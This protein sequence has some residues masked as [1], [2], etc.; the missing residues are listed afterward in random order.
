M[1]IG[2]ITTSYKPIWGG[3]EVYVHN[4]LNVFF[5]HGFEQRVYQ[6]DTGLKE[7][8]I[9]NLR[10]MKSLQK[11]IGFATTYNLSLLSKINMLKSEDV[12][13]IHYPIHFYPIW[14][15]P[16]TILLSHGVTWNCDPYFKKKIK[17]GLD[18]FAYSLCEK[19]VANESSYFREMGLAI[20]PNN[21]L[22]CEVAKNKWFIPN[23]VD[24]NKFQKVKPDNKLKK[25][26][27]I[28]VP[29]NIAYARGIHLAVLAFAKFVK[30]HSDTKLALV[31]ETIEAVRHSDRYKRYLINLISKLN[32]NDKVIF[33]GRIPWNE[34]NRIYS[35]SIMTLIPSLGVE[36]TSL[37][38]LESMACGTATLSTDRGGLADLPTVHCEA[39]EESLL[40][41]M[42]EVFEDHERIGLNQKEMVCEKFNIAEWK[43]AW[44]KVIFS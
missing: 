6:F 8:Q 28:L 29:R 18:A 11:R 22:F 14:W 17:R 38:A 1:K 39:N 7:P 2:H 4:L 34:M 35:S 40:G 42:L 37:S 32:L 3:Q 21:S 31:G 23:C 44:L 41:K 26:N 36:G 25:L 30:K 15:H 33:L 20:E 9:V 5:E 12:L 10:P 27:M 19:F 16:K 43:N 13:I 24:T